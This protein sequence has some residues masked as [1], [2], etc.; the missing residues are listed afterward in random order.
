MARNLQVGHHVVISKCDWLGRCVVEELYRTSTCGF[1]P[2]VYMAR[3]YCP[4]TDEKILIE[5][6]RLEIL[7]EGTLLD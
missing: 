1:T 3:L 7:D 6:K 2:S 4:K 5:A